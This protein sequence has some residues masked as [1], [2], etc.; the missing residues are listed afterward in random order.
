MAKLGFPNTAPNPLVGCVIVKDNK[1]IG[2]G[3][4][5]K[6]GEAHAEVNAINSVGNKNDLKSSTLYVNLEPCSHHGKTPPCADLIIEKKIKKLVVSNKDPNPVVAGRGIEKLKNA[7]VEV[8]IGA[9]EEEGAELNKRIF[10]FHTKKRPF[11]IL[12]WAQSKDGFIADNNHNSKWISNEFSRMIVHKWRSEEQAILVGTKTAKYDN[13]M[14][15]SR[16]WNTKNP[17]RLVLD[18]FLELPHSNYLFDKKVQTIVF[19]SKKE[20]TEKNLDHVKIDFTINILPQIFNILYNRNIQSLIIEGGSF[21]INSVL[22]NNLWD[23]AYVFTGQKEFGK[24]INASKINLNPT[25]E[26]QIKE[27]RLNY[28]KNYNFKYLWK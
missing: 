3:F 19:N 27:D 23:E 2:E 25:D 20:K 28:Y 4:H 21:L 7:G 24:G 10:T 16:D 26:F 5:Q 17:I 6:F 11:V 13:P 15:T 9:F 12:K 8:K 18:E 1:I 22:E 14:L